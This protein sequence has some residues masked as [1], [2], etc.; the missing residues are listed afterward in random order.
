MGGWEVRIINDV[1]MGGGEKERAHQKRHCLPQQAAGGGNVLWRWLV[2]VVASVAQ[3][4]V[5]LWRCW[6]S[7]A[8]ASDG[9]VQQLDW[10]DPAG[11]GHRQ[12][13]KRR[14]RGA[15]AVRPD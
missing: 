4:R 9:G 13:Q 10:S 7:P 2:Q 14:R 1:I 12:R 11:P 6:P 3:P 8:A 5:E 15:R